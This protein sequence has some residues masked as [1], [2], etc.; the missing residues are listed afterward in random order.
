MG[1]GSKLG[2]DQIDDDLEIPQQQIYIYMH[3]ISYYMYIYIYI[4]RD[5]NRFSLGGSSRVLGGN[6]HHSN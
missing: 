3:I 4:C 1:K 5:Y 6:F 2:K